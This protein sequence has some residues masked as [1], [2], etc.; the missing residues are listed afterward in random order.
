[1][2]VDFV[3]YVAFGYPI[4]DLVEE[5]ELVHQ[6]TKYDEDTGK[7]YTVIEEEVQY[8]IRGTDKYFDELYETEEF[9]EDKG[10]QVCKAYDYGGDLDDDDIIVG[11]YESIDDDSYTAETFLDE[12]ESVELDMANIID[13]SVLEN[14]VPAMYIFK[15]MC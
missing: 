4:T 1:M 5:Q 2:G 12:L 11:N 3:T 14:L 6:R 8:H 7:P 10:L 9:F 15:R 13:E